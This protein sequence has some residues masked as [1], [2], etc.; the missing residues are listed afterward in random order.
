MADRRYRAGG[1]RLVLAFIALVLGSASLLALWVLG[2]VSRVKAR[3]LS[4]DGRVEAV[5]R[6]WLPEPTEYGVWLRRGWQPWGTHLAQ[7]GSESMGRCRDIVW[8]P[9]GRL[10]VVVN[11]GN[12]LVV[13]DVEARRRLGLLQSDR[14]R[15]GVGLREQ[16]HHHRGPVRVDRQAGV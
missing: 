15:R 9:D 13:L 12:T 8:S 16:T 6:G 2:G 4:P 11:E 14:A 7:T 5:C 3:A 10:V 1:N